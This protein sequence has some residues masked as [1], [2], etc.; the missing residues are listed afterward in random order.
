MLKWDAAATWLYR[1]TTNYSKDWVK[2]PLRNKTCLLY[3]KLNKLWDRWQHLLT[4]PFPFL[5]K[6]NHFLSWIIDWIKTTFHSLKQCFS[7]GVP[8]HTSV[9]WASSRCA[10]KNSFQLYFTCFCRKKFQRHRFQRF[11]LAKVIQNM[12]F[13]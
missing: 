10:A 11:Y 2:L 13:D 4:F 12:S 5:K 3:K 9:P 6:K 1:K 7:T 8:R